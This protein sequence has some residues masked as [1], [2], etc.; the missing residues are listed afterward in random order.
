MVEARVKR[1]KMEESKMLKR[2]DET[3]RKAEAM[4]KMSQENEERFQMLM[5]HKIN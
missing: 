2:I 5:N 3:R 4:K 1:L